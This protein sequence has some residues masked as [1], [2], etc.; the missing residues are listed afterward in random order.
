MRSGL[1][2]MNTPRKISCGYT[3]AREDEDKQHHLQS[4]QGAQ[5]KA[6]SN[7]YHFRKC[8]C[9]VVLGSRDEVFSVCNENISYSSAVN[10]ATETYLLSTYYMFYCL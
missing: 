1:Q 2:K 5:W 9:S 8:S 6:E 4:S 10:P 7:Y 3:I